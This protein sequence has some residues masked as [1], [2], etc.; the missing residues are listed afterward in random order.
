M[1]KKCDKAN[2]PTK[3]GQN[4]TV[5]IPASDNAKGSFQNVV[6][7]VLSTS[8]DGMYK[9]GTKENALMNLYSRS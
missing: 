3:I 5:T 9:L 7:V 2:P 4:V 6:T 1:T 8:E